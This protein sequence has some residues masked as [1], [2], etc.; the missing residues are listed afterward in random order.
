MLMPQ[1]LSQP[2]QEVVIKKPISPTP[3]S[4]CDQIVGRITQL[5]EML[6]VNAPA[7]ESQIFIIHKSLID[8]PDVVHLLTDEQIGVIVSALA[9]KKNI[10]IATSEAKSKGDQKK[11]AGLSLND[12]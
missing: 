12:L 7:Y 11:L 8:D 6:R 4:A 5:Q 9:K 2:V 3:L 1:E 10:V